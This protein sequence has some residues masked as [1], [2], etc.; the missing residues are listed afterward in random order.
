LARYTLLSSLADDPYRMG[1][2]PSLQ[3]VLV[4][5]R[6]PGEDGL[7]NFASA[8]PNSPSR[9]AFAKTLQGANM[10][11]RPD[12]SIVAQSRPANATQAYTGGQQ[13]IYF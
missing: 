2:G 4:T 12:I 13:D 11:K 7:P 10:L 5:S 8:L 9:L 6:N 1:A 3:P